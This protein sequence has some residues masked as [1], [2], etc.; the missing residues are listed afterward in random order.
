MA[1]ETTEAWVLHKQALHDNRPGELRRAEIRLPEIGDHDVLA[2]PIYGCWE[3]NMTHALERRPVDLCY[4]RAEEF[5]VLGNAGVVRVLKK[6]PAVTNC[7]V[8]DVCVFGPIGTHDEY[9]HT[10]RVHGYDESGS[11]GMLAKRVVWHER[12]LSPVPKNSRYPLERWAGWS[13]RYGTAWDN[14]SLTH[15]VWKLLQGPGA[16]TYVWGWG[17]GVA[18]ATLQLARYFGCHTAMIASW[19]E[20]LA[21][22][23]HENIKPVDR[24]QFLDLDFNEERF[25]TDRAYVRRYLAAERTFLKIV[26][27]LTDG[28]GVSIFMDNIGTPVVR[29]TTRALGR[30]GVITTTGWKCGKTISYDRARE[31]IARHI[32]VHSHGCSREAGL[33]GIAFSEEHG[34]LPPENPTVYAWDDIPQ[35]AADYASSRL[36]DYA[37]LYCVNP[38]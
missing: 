35:L 9:G 7:N 18:L 1:R 26:E 32:F 2:E 10:I 12:M 8:G 5:V 33:R 11:I 21:L 37:P 17:G 38:L 28:K 30:T 29:A 23:R 27:E 24:R 14:W 22:L 6:G 13:V 20:R 15:A 19:D 36:A 3:A 25:K 34:W 4:L 16:E 31:C